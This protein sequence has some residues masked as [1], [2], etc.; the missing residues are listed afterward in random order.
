M[1][2]EGGGAVVNIDLAPVVA[3]LDDVAKSLTPDTKKIIR[4][5]AITLFTNTNFE[6]SSNSPVQIAKDCITRAMIM[7]KELK[8]QKI[9]D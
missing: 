6:L 8:E 3:K 5:C 4:D 7:A 9:I 1:D 2:E